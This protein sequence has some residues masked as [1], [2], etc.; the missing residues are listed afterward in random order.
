MARYAHKVTYVIKKSVEI[1]VLAFEKLLI[2][3]QKK[4]KVLTYFCLYIESL[5]ASCI[6]LRETPCTS[7]YLLNNF[8]RK[9]CTYL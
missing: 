4:R 8:Y 3:T 5:P 6:I 9:K 7:L 1:C 2:Q